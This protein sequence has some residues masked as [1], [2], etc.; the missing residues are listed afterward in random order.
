MKQWPD[1][2]ESLDSLKD[3]AKKLIAWLKANYPDQ[4]VLAV[5]HGI[6]NKAIQSIY[7]GKP[8]NEIQKMTNAEVRKL[9]L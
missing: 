4:T 2:V 6:V 3:R 5:G 9:E 8:M 1:D 7:Y